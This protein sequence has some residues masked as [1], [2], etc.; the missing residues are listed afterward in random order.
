M[1]QALLLLASAPPDRSQPTQ[2][3]ATGYDVSIRAS[4]SQVKTYDAPDRD[5]LDA[6]EVRRDLERLIWEGSDWPPNR[7]QRRAASRRARTR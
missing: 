4:T 3:Q 5:S 6:A 1:I 2:E 7:A